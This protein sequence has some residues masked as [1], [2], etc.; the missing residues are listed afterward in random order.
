MSISHALS[1]QIRK[2]ISRKTVSPRLNKEKLVAR[3]PCCKPLISKKTRKVRQ[4]HHRA[5][6]IDRETIEYGSL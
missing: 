5:Y 3:I 2:P 1:E 6:R 4:L